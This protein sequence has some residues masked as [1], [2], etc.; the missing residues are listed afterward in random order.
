MN[1]ESRISY[2]LQDF[3]QIR[4]LMMDPFDIPD[5]DLELFKG[6]IQHPGKSKTGAKAQTT[7]KAKKEPTPPQIPQ[8]TAIPTSAEGSVFSSY[9]GKHRAF[10]YVDVD[11]FPYDPKSNLV[12]FLNNIRQLFLNDAK[13][14]AFITH[15]STINNKYQRNNASLWTEA[16]QNYNVDVRHIQPPNK[17]QKNFSDIELACAVFQD[18]ISCKP[19]KVVLCSGDS[20]FYLLAE[21]LKEFVDQVVVIGKKDSNPRL[22]NVARFLFFEQLTGEMQPKD[23]NQAW[24]VLHNALK[25]WDA[26]SV[27]IGELHERLVASDNTYWPFVYGCCKTEELLRKL[28]IDTSAAHLDPSHL[29]ALAS[30]F[31][32]FSQPYPVPTRPTHSNPNPN[33][34]PNPK[35]KSK[36]KGKTNGKSKKK[37][38]NNQLQPTQPESRPA[39]VSPDSPVLSSRPRVAAHQAPQGWREES[40][41]LSSKTSKS[42]KGSGFVLNI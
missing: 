13:I 7:Q 27:S 8:H 37:S 10:V 4:D 41:S 28:D 39:R 34:G 24:P 42:K 3:H 21:T 20:D 12:N 40:Q 5:L 36:N 15:D 2:A 29:F 30:Q 6:S 38:M 14:V 32:P 25:H 11:N 26:R 19:K 22:K 18:V 35:T 16:I 33:P 17:S 9:T 1:L 23:V 31:E